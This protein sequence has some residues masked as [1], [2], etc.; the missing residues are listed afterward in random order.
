MIEVKFY[1]K[2]K[3]GEVHT[4]YQYFNNPNKA[5]RFMYKCKNSKTLRYSG[6]FT[7]DNPSDT[8]YILRRF[9]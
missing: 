4:G 3:F 2:D 8:E 9:R 6:D 7:C 1:Y 5:L